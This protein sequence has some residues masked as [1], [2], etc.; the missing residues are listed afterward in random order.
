[1]ARRETSLSRKIRNISLASA[2][3]LA[4]ALAVAPMAF[5]CTLWGAAGEKVEGG[6]TLIAK[7]RDWA[8][9]Q[10]QELRRIVPQEG[11]RY[12]GLFASDEEG[13]GLKAG[14]NERGLTIVTAT[15]AVIPSEKRGTPSR[16][17]IS[18]AEI[19][20]TCSSVDDV[21]S[22]LDRFTHACYYLVADKDKVAV[23]EVAP[24][25]KPTVRITEN[26]T[27]AQTNHYLG[28]EM[29]ILNKKVSASSRKRY[30]RIQSLLSGDPDGFSLDDF[31]A[32]SEDRNAGPDNSIYRTGSTPTRSRT[33][34]TWII[35]NPA[36]GT[37]CLYVRVANPDKPQKTMRLSLDETFWRGSR[38]GDKASG[39]TE[40]SPT[41]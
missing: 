35:E 22:Q 16:Q 23:I 21:L 3:L 38:P 29:R 17:T 30:E 19:L 18:S 24:G 1:M 4:L 41:A 28:E 13:T 5:A 20:K 2:A 36:E 26:G 37:P 31:V 27:I 14:I 8:P 10:T 32:F 25:R 12:L 7:N 40:E 34:A 33:L 9:N 6:G 11:F 39:K 15:A